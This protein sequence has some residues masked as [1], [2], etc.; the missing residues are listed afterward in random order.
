MVFAH[1]NLAMTRTKDLKVRPGGVES[2]EA[3]SDIGRMSRTHYINASCHVIRGRSLSPR[4]VGLL[5]TPIL[6]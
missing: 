2:S 1:R 6:C 4:Q 5:L 3:A